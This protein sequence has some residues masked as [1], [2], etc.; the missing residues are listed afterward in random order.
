MG[1]KIR[2]ANVPSRR[3]RPRGGRLVPLRRRPGRVDEGGHALR[4]VLV[5]QVVPE[6]APEDLPALRLP[7]VSLLVRV[8]DPLRREVGRE[9]GEDEVPG[10]ARPALPQDARDLLLVEE[11]PDA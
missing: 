8:D 5:P 7:G 10:D 2:V 11:G 9:P 4:T 3:G 1:F 6:E